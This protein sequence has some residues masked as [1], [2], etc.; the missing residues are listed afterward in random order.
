[1]KTT[2]GRLRGVQAL[3]L[4]PLLNKP[5]PIK[6][7]SIYSVRRPLLWGLVGLVTVVFCAAPNFHP[8]AVL[9]LRYHPVLD[10]LF[11]GGYFFVITLFL[12]KP[13]RRRI[14]GAGAWTL[15]L[16]LSAL[17]EG[18][19]AV[20]PGRSVSLHDLFANALGITGATVIQSLRHVCVYYFKFKYP[21]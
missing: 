16:A 5:V 6:N 14:G 19:Q 1:M 3:Q 12:Y 20:V 21:P 15:L 2:G 8:E 17:L 11:H 18:V 7:D 10:V 4:Q 13:L 9:G